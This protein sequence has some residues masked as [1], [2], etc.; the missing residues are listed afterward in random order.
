MGCEPSKEDSM[1][2][3]RSNIQTTVA[4]KALMDD[5]IKKMESRPLSTMDCDMKRNRL[6][7]SRGKIVANDQI[8]DVEFQQFLVLPKDLKE[9]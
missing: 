4:R 2:M 1:S 3:D 6:Q 7:C 9:N 8:V 5:T